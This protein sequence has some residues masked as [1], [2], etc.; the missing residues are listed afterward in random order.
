MRLNRS[1]ILWLLAL[2][3][4]LPALLIAYLGQ[5]SRLMGDDWCF[6]NTA[7]HLGGRD[8]FS[9]WLNNWHSSYTYVALDW[10]L[11]HFGPENM[12]PIVP[13]IT[14]SLW[15]LGL[16]WLYCL[17]LRGLD[18]DAN[19]FLIALVLAFL[20]LAAFVK[21]V[22]DWEALY[23]YA[24]STRHSLPVGFFLIYLALSW[25]L[26]SR[27]A[28]GSR[29]VVFAVAGA[30]AC[31]VIAGL[32]QLQTILQLIC[33]TLLMAGIYGIIGGPRSKPYLA[34][35][36]AGWLGNAVGLILQL[37]LPGSATRMSDMGTVERYNQIRALP[38]LIVETLETSAAFI[39]HQGNIAGFILLFAAGLVAALLLVR[40]GQV[41]S[42]RGPSTGNAGPGPAG[43]G[44]RY[45]S[46]A[47]LLGAFAMLALTQVAGLHFLASAL[48]Y[49][50]ALILFAVL[51]A[52]LAAAT[53][54]C[55][56]RRLVLAAMCGSAFAYCSLALS[57]ASGHFSI[58]IV[59]ERTL[60]FAALLSVLSGLVWGGCLG[61]L[62]QRG[63]TRAES[64]WTR[65]MIGLGSLV[66]ALLFLNILSLQAGLIPDFATYARE[67]NARHHRILQ[68]RADGERSITVT[69]YSYHMTQAISPVDLE[70]VGWNCQPYYYGLEAIVM[71]P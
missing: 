48:L 5:F 26:A 7:L 40:P 57:I 70:I 47:L 29:L 36:A 15:L 30:V 41:R 20:T 50:G 45:R 38:E 14:F 27:R 1:S 8:Y 19:R 21:G 25:E 17:V 3:A 56:S 58:G 35:Y 71:A 4:S 67:W 61:F 9:F 24:A 22:Y 13:A 68:L 65:G 53:S 52:K 11:K 16:L 69:P 49:I 66:A 28:S 42:G 31:F 44:A 54:D 32:S 33:L 51:A 39:G 62:I 23:W 34:L 10:A 60:T 55:L 6:F 63:R 37:S 43:A 2:V 46:A 12:P 64:A 18:I 59:Y